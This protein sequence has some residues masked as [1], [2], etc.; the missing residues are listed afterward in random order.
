MPYHYRITLENLTDNRDD[1]PQNRSLTFDATNH[2]DILEIIEKVRSKGILPD[3]DVAAFCTGLKLFSEVMMVH[4]KEALFRDLI[5]AFRDFM[6]R[7]KRG[8]TA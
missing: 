7:L 3:S 1:K 8:E 4:R 2:D 6:L 5:P